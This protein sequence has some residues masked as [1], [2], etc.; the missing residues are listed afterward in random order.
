MSL[1]DQW[2]WHAVAKPFQIPNLV[3]CYEGNKELNALTSFV[4]MM[5]S[6]VK[7]TLSR[8]IVP[9]ATRIDSR[10]KIGPVTLILFF[11]TY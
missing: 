2:Q 7:F 11:E 4:N 3:Q 8:S 1:V 10:L 6:G 9:L 5:I